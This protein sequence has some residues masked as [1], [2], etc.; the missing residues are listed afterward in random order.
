MVAQVLVGVTIFM[1]QNNKSNDK[2]THEIKQH[3][4]NNNNTRIMCRHVS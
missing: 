2:T 4:N 1:L 3:K